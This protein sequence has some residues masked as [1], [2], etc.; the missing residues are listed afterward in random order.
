LLILPIFKANLFSR[1]VLI[2]DGI[3]E[4]VMMVRSKRE[5]AIFLSK[6]EIFAHSKIQLEQ[7]PTDSQIAGDL[8]W[9][10]YMHKDIEGKV[11]ADLGCG[12]GILGI[13]AYVVGAKEIYFVDVDKDALAVLRD[14]LNRIGLDD[15]Y[16]VLEQDISKVDLIADVVIQNPPFGTR[17]EHADKQFLETAFRVAPLVYS[18]HKTSTLSFVQQFAKDNGYRVTAIIPY[19]FPLKAQYEHHKK[20]IERIDVSCVRLERIKN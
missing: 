11:I 9:M 7:Y 12:T 6:L 16:T 10:A 3:F 18:F 15:N 20:K 4:K 2:N 19:E 1:V 17:T 14:N 8:I 5:L 13:G